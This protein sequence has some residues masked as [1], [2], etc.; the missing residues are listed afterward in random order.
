MRFAVRDRQS[1]ATG[2]AGEFVEMSD[3]T[4]G[5]F[6]LSGIL[7]RLDRS[8]TG[9][10]SQGGSDADQLALTSASGV[11]RLSSGDAAVLHLRNL[12][13]RDGPG[14]DESLARNGASVCGRAR[15]ARATGWRRFAI[16]RGR[17]PQTWRRAS[18]WQLRAA[19]RGDGER[20]QAPGQS[21]DGR[22]TDRLRRRGRCSEMRG[23]PEP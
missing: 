22:S 7:L 16:R 9:T 8:T 4:G 13:C 12:Q 6:A 23:N 14:G 15:D 11:A 18:A 3:V 10:A 20:S 1:G 21:Y 5:A 19:D 2:S 17:R